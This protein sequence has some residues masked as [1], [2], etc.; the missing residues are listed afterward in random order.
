MNRNDFETTRAIARRVAGSRT[1]D[2]HPYLVGVAGEH[3]GRFFPLAG[4]REVTIGRTEDCEIAV[5]L[6]DIV[7]RRHARLE[8]GADGEWRVTDLNSLNGTLVNGREV[9]G[10]VL[11]RGDRLFLGQS[12][13]F[14]FDYL[15]DAERKNWESAAI[16]ALTD[17]YNRAFFEKQFPEIVSLARSRGRPLSVVMADADHFKSIND[18]H[19]HQAGDHALHVIA[20]ALDDFLT[21]QRVE[22]LTFRYG[23]EEFAIV[24]PGCEHDACAGVAEGLRRAV[25]ETRCE[26]EGTHVPLTISL[27][28][29]V[30]DPERHAGPEQLL[31][32]ADQALY[33]AKHGGRNR[34]V[35]A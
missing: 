35:I 26:F 17:C 12:T 8:L 21:V 18:N 1:S 6:D 31:K 29:A 3:A 15:S 33:K 22:A 4:L 20:A 14:K 23:G 27:G 2:E 30:F 11:K 34:V 32:A 19:G 24:I 28:A 5:V 7:S 9:K 10:S 25:A 13:I 16:D